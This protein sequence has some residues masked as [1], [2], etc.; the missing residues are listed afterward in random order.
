M[1]CV[2]ITNK[3]FEVNS[4]Y[5]PRNTSYSCMCENL[6]DCIVI[7]VIYAP[8]VIVITYVQDN[9]YITWKEYTLPIKPIISCFFQSSVDFLSDQFFSKLQGGFNLLF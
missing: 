9:S 5:I 7:K 2:S 8:Y 1:Q 6:I 4:N 3:F